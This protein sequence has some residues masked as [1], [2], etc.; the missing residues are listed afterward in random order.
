MATTV[1]S[2]EGYI[3][4]RGHR[5][6]YRSVGADMPGHLP[7]VTLHGGPG[8]THRYLQPLE[9]LAATGRRVIFYDQVGCGRSD[10]PT[11]PSLYTPQTFVAELDALR[12]QLDLPRVHV[13]GQSWGGMLAMEYAL[14]QPSGLASIT[15]IERTLREHEAAGTTTDPA[16][17]AACDAFYQ[18]HVCRLDPLP[19]CVSETFEALAK[20]GYVYNLMNGPSEFHCIGTL[21]DWDITDRLHEIAVPTLLLSGRHD[22][23]TPLIVGTIHERI[24]GS[25]WIVFEESSHM[26]H[27]E[28]PEAFNT[29]VR[30]F[31]AGVEAA[32]DARP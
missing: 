15:E 32:P 5:T 22:E 24:R 14:S 4:F 9:A 30:D 8:A 13:L 6:W 21:K 1:P 25:A 16:Y 10:H 27:V 31:L 3:D 12:A 23:A 17:L 18:R 29:A 7:L 26:P 2:H 20:D 19:A 11:D 28:E